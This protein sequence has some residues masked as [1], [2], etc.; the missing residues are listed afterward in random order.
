MPKILA[1]TIRPA[2][3]ADTRYRIHLYR[4]FFREA[5]FL[6]HHES[7]LTHTWWRRQLEGRRTLGLAA[8]YGKAFLVR[9]A[10]IALRAKA[11][12][13]VWISRELAPLG[14][15]LLEQILFRRHPRVVLDIDDAVY[16]P[17]LE[18][19]GFIHK[20]L[21]DFGKFAR[22]APC[23]A[24]IVCG[25]QVLADYFSAFSKNVAVLPTVVEARR[26]AAITPKPSRMPRIG[27]IGTPSNRYQLDLIREPLCSLAGETSF[28]WIVVG[29][30]HPL[31][32]NL[33][34]IL[35]L[36]WEMEKELDYFSKFD[37][38]VMPV[39]DNPFT[40][41]KCAFKIVQ[42]M[43]AGIPCVASPVGANKD[44]IRHGENGL[45]ADSPSEWK[46]C[47]RRLLDDP[48]ERRRMGEAGRRTVAEIYSIETRWKQ[49]LAIFQEVISDIPL[50]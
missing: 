20:R 44:I 2:E 35:N 40:R 4:P 25:N 26:Y 23:Y 1:L 16:L 19:G 33:P 31:D 42:Y 17:D 27:W 50:A 43:A 10:Q 39:Q 12:D 5:G 37:I 21:R 3:A 15:P 18:S 32:W 22:L 45:L 30:S 28:A 14:P 47:L 41:G 36:D 6:V 7:F 49:Y 29:L 11:Y 34:N 9:L 38:G 24:K 13:A 8:Y 48:K 46:D